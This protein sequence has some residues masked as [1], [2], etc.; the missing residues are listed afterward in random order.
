MNVIEF[1]RSKLETVGSMSDRDVLKKRRR[2]CS[3]W[4]VD[5]HGE[6][7]IS[8]YAHAT[9]ATFKLFSSSATHTSRSTMLIWY[10]KS[11]FVR[12]VSQLA[13]CF[14]N[15]SRNC[16]E[17]IGAIK[18]TFTFQLKGVNEFQGFH[19]RH[20]GQFWIFQALYFFFK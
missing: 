9:S 17:K 5:F 1:E 11:D 7:A 8:G 19:F 3:F 20:C 15:T 6:P 12:S 10:L 18:E 14:E 13:N 4:N 16:T 2:G